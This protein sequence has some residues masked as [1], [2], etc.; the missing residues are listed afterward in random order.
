MLEE[1]VSFASSE[2][3]QINHDKNSDDQNIF[4]VTVDV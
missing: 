3:A 2:S 1:G 4:K